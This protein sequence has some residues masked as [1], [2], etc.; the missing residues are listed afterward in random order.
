MFFTITFKLRHHNTKISGQTP[1]R[2]VRSLTIKLPWVYLCKTNH[3]LTA[4]YLGGEGV[5]NRIQPFPF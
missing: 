3:D 4:I 5:G 1:N 2:F